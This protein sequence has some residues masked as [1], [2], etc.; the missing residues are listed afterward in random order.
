M[1]SL[2]GKQVPLRL[3]LGFSCMDYPEKSHRTLNT[4]ALHPCTFGCECSLMKRTLLQEPRNFPNFI[5]AS[6]GMIFLKVD[7]LYLPRMRYKR[8]KFGCDRSIMNG[9]SLGK[10]DTFSSVSRLPFE[11]H[12]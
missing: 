1:G 8:C 10:Q 7:G 6:N 4:H 3:Y 12:G 9:T 5:W 11:G 2:L